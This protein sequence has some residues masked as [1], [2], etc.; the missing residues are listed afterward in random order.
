[1]RRL[2]RMFVLATGCAAACHLVAREA[3]A[4]LPSCV[5]TTTYGE[6]QGLT[7]GGACAFLGIPYAA[8]PVGELR[9]KRPQA[10][11]AWAPAVLNAVVPPPSCAQLN[12]ATGAPQGT[13]DCLKLN[14]WTPNPLSANAPVIVWFHGGSFVN[15]SANSA[16]QN[17]AALAASTGAIVVA[18]NYRLGPFGFLGHTALATEDSAA[19]N[20]GLLD[21]RAVLTWVHDQIAAFG[22]DPDNVS[23]A[24][25]SAGGH[26]VA[27]H[28]VSPG[29]AGLFH[30]AIM[31]SGF[32][33][34]RWRTAADARVQ[35]DEFAAVLGCT[36]VDPATVVACLRSTS[37]SAVLLAR[38]PALFEQVLETGRSQWTPIVD[39]VEVPDQPRALFEQG[40]FARVP[41]IL[42]TTR[43]EGWTWVNRSFPTSLTEEQYVDTLQ[44]EF[45]SDAAA[46]LAEYAVGAFPSPKDALVDLIGDV[47]YVCEARRVARQFEATKTPV[48]LYSFEY[49]VDPVIPG[50]VAHGIDVNFV[51]GT[52]FGPPLFPAYTLG[53]ADLALARAIGAYWTQFAST[54][55]PNAEDGT[56]VEW[57][58]FKHPT[59]SGRGADLYLILDGAIRE[60]KRPRESRCD[61][62]EPF[63]F[64]S[65]TGSV[66]A[67]LR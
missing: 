67:S 54:G 65:V 5:V 66:P 60:G 19:G 17:G 16:P 34:V 49:E 51:F 43:D 7:S 29:S 35:G 44:T 13:E 46:I 1:M 40:A 62:W 8:A 11:A 55:S 61:F 4:Q 12:I 52:N 22:G 15:A 57:P 21:Q 18:P 24:G 26:S 10:A 30:R 59:G 56:S 33:S 9:W 2:L 32:A 37:T 63:F 45:G 36:S 3:H 27:L 14:I 41:I 42:G 28:L 39:G 23:I 64:R 38:P 53:P 47:E 50:R 48:Y 31:Q 25:Q 6:V 20:Y 58:A